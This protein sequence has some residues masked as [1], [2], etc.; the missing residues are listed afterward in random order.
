MKNQHINL[1]EI[2]PLSHQAYTNAKNLANSGEEYSHLIK[3]MIPEHALRL[4]IFIQSLPDEIA[5]QT[6]YGRFVKKDMPPTS[7]QKKTQGKK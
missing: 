1:A 2:Y 3:L 7:K 6:I 5:N 4:K